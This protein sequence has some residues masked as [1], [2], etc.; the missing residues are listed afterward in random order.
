MAETLVVTADRADKAAL[1]GEIVPQIA[2]LLEGEIDIIAAMA[3]T[4]AALRDAFGFFWIGFYRVVGGE[5]V[6]GPFQGPIACT[7]IAHGKGVC[8]SSWAQAATIIV[9]NV[10]EFPGHIA[11]SS[12]SRSEIVVPVRDRAGVVRAVLDVDSDRLAA[13]DDR[14]RHALEAVCALFAAVYAAG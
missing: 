6:L 13:F 7:R 3:N 5:L 8:G 11:C 4:A 14:D 10:D 2:A 12:A 1:Y 9:P